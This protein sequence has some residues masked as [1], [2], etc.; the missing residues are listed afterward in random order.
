M[1]TG[2]PP[3]PIAGKCFR[4]DPADITGPTVG[5]ESASTG[6]DALHWFSFWGMPLVLTKHT[7]RTPNPRC[8]RFGALT[9]KTSFRVLDKELCFSKKST[10]YVLSTRPK[11]ACFETFRHPAKF[12]V[13][14]LML[15]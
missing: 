15:S 8:Q 4:F 9:L 1:S 5:N 11:S 10:I 13:A 6:F 2:P 3:A 12:V 14:L 7:D